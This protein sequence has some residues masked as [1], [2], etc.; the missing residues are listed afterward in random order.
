MAHAC[1]GR[2]AVQRWPLGLVRVGI[3]F[4]AQ[5]IAAAHQR[6]TALL[7]AAPIPKRAKAHG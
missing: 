3:G 5:I 1:I 4:L 6:N 2:S 7:L